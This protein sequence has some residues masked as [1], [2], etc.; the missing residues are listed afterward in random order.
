MKGICCSCYISRSLYEMIFGQE[1]P[2][3]MTYLFALGE[4]VKEIGESK[5]SELI[6]IMEEQKERV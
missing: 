3:K 6:K 1:M 4:V 5:T 2:G